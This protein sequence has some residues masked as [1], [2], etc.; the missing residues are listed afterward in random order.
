M[1]DCFCYSP[2]MAEDIA[3]VVVSHVAIWIERD[4]LAVVFLGLVKTTAPHMKIGDLHETLRVFAL[5]QG[6]AL[7]PVHKNFLPKNGIYQSLNRVSNSLT[8]AYKRHQADAISMQIRGAWGERQPAPR[9]S[10][11]WSMADTFR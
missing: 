11:L 6:A 8:S 5:C 10:R 2:G 1:P 9:A 7:V 3:K 4:S